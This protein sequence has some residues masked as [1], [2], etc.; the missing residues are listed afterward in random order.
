MFL[1]KLGDAACLLLGTLVQRQGLFQADQAFF[2]P[3]LFGG[4]GADAVGLIA[5]THQLVNPFSDQVTFLIG[6]LL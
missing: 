5:V 3:G 6:R 1:L 2:K 4:C